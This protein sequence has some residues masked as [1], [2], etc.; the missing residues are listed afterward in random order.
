MPTR[1]IAAESSANLACVRCGAARALKPC[2]PCFD[3]RA[4]G[5]RVSPWTLRPIRAR[6]PGKPTEQTCWSEITPMQRIVIFLLG[7]VLGGG[8]TASVPPGQAQDDLT[9]ALP[10]P[11]NHPLLL[12]ITT[13]DSCRGATGLEFARARLKFGLPAAVFLT[14]DAVRLALRTGGQEKKS[15]MPQVPR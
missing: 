5:S 7:L 11:E 6:V 8:L 10:S 14:L 2:R 1:S 9:G 4:A 3:V 15:S 12:H 13:G